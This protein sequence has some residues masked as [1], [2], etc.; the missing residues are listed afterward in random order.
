ME[1]QKNL[2]TL[3]ERV[4]S[5]I[6]EYRKKRGLSQQELADLCGISKRTIGK[7][8]S[9]EYDCCVGTLGVIGDALGIK[10]VLV[11]NEDLI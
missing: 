5:K 8:E 9:G 3:E 6:K 7:I 11:P 1:E 10:F 2:P 4:A